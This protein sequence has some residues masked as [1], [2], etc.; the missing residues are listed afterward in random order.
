M[1]CSMKSSRYLDFLDPTE[2]LKNNII[3]LNCKSQFW[4]KIFFI[5]LAIKTK[6]VN[7]SLLILKH[8]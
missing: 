4:K 5:I 3:L 7:C 1:S 8:I 2:S 6:F